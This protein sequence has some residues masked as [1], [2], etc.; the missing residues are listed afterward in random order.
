MVS[1]LPWGEWVKV[2]SLL[3]SF[4]WYATQVEEASVSTI[5]HAWWD[6]TGNALA[7]LQ[8]WS[9]Y[10]WIDDILVVYFQ[11]QQCCL[12]SFKLKQL[13]PIVKQPLTTPNYMDDVSSDISDMTLVYKE[14]RNDI[15]NLSVLANNMADDVDLI[16]SILKLRHSNCFNFKNMERH[17]YSSK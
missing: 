11:L 12:S 4:Y 5:L 6:F 10:F 8:F 7:Q 2:W 3:V 16:V 15:D 14:M 13:N 9:P 1:E 17:C